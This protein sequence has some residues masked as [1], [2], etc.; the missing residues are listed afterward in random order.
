M[1]EKTRQVFNG[2]L[3]LTAS[4]QAEL[5]REIRSYR[6]QYPSEQVR[7]RESVDRAS[8]MHLGPV[9]EVCACCGK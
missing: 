1:N 5:E 3:H 8:K 9:S 7:I 6:V 2:W 4:E